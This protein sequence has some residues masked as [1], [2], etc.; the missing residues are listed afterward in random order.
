MLSLNILLL[1]LIFVI[2]GCLILITVYDLKN[3]V[4]PNGFTLTF[5][6]TT[7][8][9]ITI[10]GIDRGNLFDTYLLS[11]LAGIVAF[12]FFFTFVYFSKETWMGGGDAKFAFG[13][14]LLLGPANTFLTVL[15]ASIV[16]SIYGISVLLIK[17]I[18]EEKKDTIISK[19]GLV[20][21]SHE[22]PFGPFLALGT[23]ISFLFG[24]QLISW[25][26]RIFLGL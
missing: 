10:S 12:L 22:V 18:K 1:I 25:Y 5:F 20:R 3:K 7:I 4:I 11:L 17:K 26:A 2:F 24:S 23:I 6:I 13:I 16:G 8:V 9:Y 14:G 21:N 15:I 19:G